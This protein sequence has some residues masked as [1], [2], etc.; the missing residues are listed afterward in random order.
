MAVDFDK[1]QHELHIGDPWCFDDWCLTVAKVDRSVAA[2][3]VN[4][5]L[6][7][8]IFSRARRVAQRARG[9]WIYLIDDR[10]HL[11]SPESDPR[12]A[13]L[14]VRLEPGESVTTLRNFRVPSEVGRLG[15]I[16]GHGGRYCGAMNLLIIGAGGCLFGKPALVRIQ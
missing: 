1:P 4:Y 9:A 12:A 5:E 14:D 10:G 11:Y 6:H 16:T 3:E 2:S 13:P 15:L 7:L 8:E